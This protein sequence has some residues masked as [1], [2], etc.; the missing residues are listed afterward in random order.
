MSKSGSWQVIST[1]LC[2]ILLRC[3]WV[4][5]Y[6]VINF[7]RLWHFTWHMMSVVNLHEVSN[8]DLGSAL[9]Y[10]KLIRYRLRLAALCELHRT[11]M[12]YGATF[13]VFLYLPQT[14]STE[15]HLIHVKFRVLLRP[16]FE[17][18]T[19]KWN[20]WLTFT[21]QKLCVMFCEITSKRVIDK[22]E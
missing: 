14:T 16:D 11:L 1:P 17:F 8:K 18:F 7:R 3:H 4:L 13:V 22:Q 12:N 2:N 10:S 9:S 6:E 21:E 19:Q 20:R 5:N 15:L